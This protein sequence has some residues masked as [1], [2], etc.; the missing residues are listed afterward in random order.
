[1]YILESEKVL[2]IIIIF[3]NHVIF[4]ICFQFEDIHKKYPG[5]TESRWQII[6]RGDLEAGMSTVECRLSIGDPIEIE[7]KKD[8]RFETWFY[9]GKTL[10]FENGT[11][12]RYK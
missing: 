2:D 12:Q 9:N 5:I 1:M 6:S 11:L 10:E 8:S 7:L 4:Q 3:D